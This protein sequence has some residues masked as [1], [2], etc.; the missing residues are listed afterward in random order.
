MSV[1][2]GL[3]LGLDGNLYIASYGTNEMVVLTRDGLTEVRRVDM[4]NDPADR[5][6]RAG[7]DRRE[8]ELFGDEHVAGDR[9]G[10]HR[11][12]G[13]VVQPTTRTLGQATPPMIGGMPMLP[14]AVLTICGNGHAW[15][16]EAYEATCFDYAPEDGDKNACACLIPQ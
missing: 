5:V 15:V 14:D 10:D 9:G 4:G 11:S 8:R 1:C 13:G 6:R 12:G 7:A 2:A 16:C 3:A